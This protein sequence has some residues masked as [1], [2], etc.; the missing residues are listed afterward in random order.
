ME[1]VIKESL[2]LYPTVPMIA[3][4]SDEE[5]T[6]KSGYVLPKQAH[7]YMHLY[8]IHR[9]SKYWTE[10]DKFDPDRF[11]PENSV[12]RHPYAFVPFSSG[13]RNCMGMIKF[14]ISFHMNESIMK[15]LKK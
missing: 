11:L 7:I 10:P 3:R 6:T 14:E 15:T 9:N 8:D 13:P 2:R 5:I 4:C 1:R 12:D